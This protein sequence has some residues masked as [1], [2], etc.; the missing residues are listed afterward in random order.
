MPES[1]VENLRVISITFR[2]LDVELKSWSLQKGVGGGGSSSS[3]S[4]PLLAGLLLLVGSGPGPS[5]GPAG[6]SSG[7]EVTGTGG[8]ASAAGGAAFT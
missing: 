2:L 7:W 1:L 4:P 6:R 8:P 5:P 3:S